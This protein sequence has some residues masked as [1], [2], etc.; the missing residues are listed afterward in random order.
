MS[1]AEKYFRI[2][3][4]FYLRVIICVCIFTLVKPELIY[5]LSEALEQL[6]ALQLQKADLSGA[7]TQERNVF[8]RIIQEVTTENNLLKQ[9]KEQLKGWLSNEQ[10]RG[11]DK[12]KLIISLQDA[13]VELQAEIARKTEDALRKEWQLKELKEMLFGPR[14]EKFIPESTSTQTAIQ[15]TLGADFDTAEVEAIIEQTKAETNTACS[16]TKTSRRRKRHQAHKGRRAIPTHLE[17][18]TIIFDFP[19]DKTG[20]K[21]M[22]KKVSVYYDFIPGKLIRK[23]EQ[24]LQYKSTDGKIHCTPVLPRMVERG[25]VSNRLLAHLHSERFVYYMPYYRQQQRFERLMG[26]SFA[27]S[28]IDHWEEVCYKKLKRLLKLLKKMIQTSSYIK[29]DETTLR[30]LH[31]EG[32]G[33]A[34]NGWMWVFH[35]PELKLVLFEFHPGRGHEIPKEILKDF[36]GVLQTDALSSYTAA[37][38]ENK[39]VTLMGCLAHIRRGFKN[40]Q[41]QNKVLA[42]QVLTYFNIIYRIE[43]YAKRKQ[44]S[45]DQRLA[46][47]QKYSR[48]FIDKI[49]SW[50]DEQKDKQV[51]DTPLAKAITYANNQ[52]DKLKILFEDG[53]IDVDN[54]STERAVRPITLFRKNSLFASNEHGGERAAL[55]YSLVETCKLNGIDPFEYLNDVYDRLYDCTAEELLQLLP[56]YWKPAIAKSA[57][58]FN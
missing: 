43:A 54:N 10:E 33:K 17:T 52:W 20:L 3:L 6:A 39:N 44:F 47:R 46:L 14:S 57:T 23:E 51:P 4:Y 32:Q 48:P 36:K 55:F 19:G 35:A 42:D 31:D 40:A 12:D 45:S 34:S 22:G 8:S 9:D 21:S 5:T 37:F 26:V 7:L 38:K 29:A 30:Y 28:T 18:E 25:I 58:I 13:I 49:R 16:T 41:R 56:P 27:A 1:Q 2:E 24:H 50:L 53:K 11:L 15:Q